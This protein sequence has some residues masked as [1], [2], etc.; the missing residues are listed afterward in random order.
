MNSNSSLSYQSYSKNYRYPTIEKS[1]S[2]D[3]RKLLKVFL[4]TRLQNF[5]CNLY[6]K[7]FQFYLGKNFELTM[8]C[9]EMDRKI[10]EILIGEIVATGEY[11]LEGIATYTKMPL[12]IIVDTACGT[13]NQLSVTPWTRIVDLYMQ[14]KPDI[15]KT[16]HEKLVAA[17]EIDNFR[18][19]SILNEI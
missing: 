3:E 8:E 18:I 15:S 6:H 5:F 2:K 16:F 14:V 4:V 12:D 13:S 1:L 17:L 19:S 7:N 10:I 9:F 11:T